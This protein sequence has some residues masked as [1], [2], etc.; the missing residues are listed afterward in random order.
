ML[1][2]ESLESPRESRKRIEEGGFQMNPKRAPILHPPT[3]LLQSSR[4]D[5]PRTPRGLSAGPRYAI[6]V[7]VATSHEK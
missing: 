4:D 2:R 6:R 1:P 3:L 5:G 7:L